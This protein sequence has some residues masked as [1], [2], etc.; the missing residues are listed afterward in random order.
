[1]SLE[2]IAFFIVDKMSAYVVGGSSLQTAV[3][4]SCGELEAIYRGNH[5]SR[6]TS[7]VWRVTPPPEALTI[8]AA[9]IKADS[10]IAEILKSYKQEEGK[11]REEQAPETRH[12]TTQNKTF[13]GF[14]KMA[15]YA[16]V[17]P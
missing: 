14:E 17:T 10:M 5:H 12:I 1:M 16:R 11:G 8:D 9:M 2:G 7:G 4:F 13:N 15:E 3:K 6:D